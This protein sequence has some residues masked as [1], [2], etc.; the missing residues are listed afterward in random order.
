ME[1]DARASWTPIDFPRACPAAGGID[2]AHETAPVGMGQTGSWR[3]WR[4]GWSRAARYAIRTVRDAGRASF[5]VDA[6]SDGTA[7]VCASD[8]SGCILP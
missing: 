2:H 3:F 4:Y 7:Y 5:R 8:F 6:S 1:K